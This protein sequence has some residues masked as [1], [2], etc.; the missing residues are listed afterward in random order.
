MY[1]IPFKVASEYTKEAEGKKLKNWEKL[2]MKWELA[3]MQKDG[4]YYM[5]IK[6]TEL[7][8]EIS[9]NSK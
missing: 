5:I 6:L 8:T 1:Q 3:T 9:Q 4:T 7:K 2:K